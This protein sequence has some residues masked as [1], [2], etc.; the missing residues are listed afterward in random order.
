MDWEL[1][2]A[3]GP[4]SSAGFDIESES[5]FLVKANQSFDIFLRVQHSYS[6]LARGQQGAGGPV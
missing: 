5:V 3:V 1:R 2:P 4:P 6:F